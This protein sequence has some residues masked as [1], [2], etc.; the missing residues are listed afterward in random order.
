MRSSTHW[1]LTIHINL[2]MIFYTHVEHSPTKTV[3]IKYYTTETNTKK[4]IVFTW[5]EDRSECCSRCWVPSTPGS[6]SC[7]QRRHSPPRTRHTCLW[8]TIMQCWHDSWQHDIPVSETPSCNTNMTDDS[9]TYPSL[10]HHHAMLT[11]QHDIPVSETRSCN[12]DMTDDSMTYPS[13]KHHHAML[14]WQMTA[15]D[16]C[17]WNTIM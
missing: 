4:P 5:Q 12:T 11:W 15:W 1:A 10:K 7:R 17:L 2:N 14:T 16:T 3:C 6:P 8:N 13:M 9:K